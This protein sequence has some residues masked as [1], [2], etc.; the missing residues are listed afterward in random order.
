VTRP[1]HVDRRGQRQDGLLAV[2]QITVHGVII[3]EFRIE[4]SR[5]HGLLP[6]V[7]MLTVLLGAVRAL[8]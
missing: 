8:R 4:D 7:G 5:L 1:Q 3:A 6:E 2:P